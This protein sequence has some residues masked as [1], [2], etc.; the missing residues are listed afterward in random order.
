MVS[1]DTGGYRDP[2]ETA[3]ATNE[4]LAVI[5]PCVRTFGSA[6]SL[7]HL[8]SPMLPAPPAAR[9][10]HQRHR[11][12]GPLRSIWPAP[13]GVMTTPR[14]PKTAAT[15]LESLLYVSPRTPPGKDFEM[16]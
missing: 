7:H 8:K 14:N 3:S 1:T 15:I 10:G 5:K 9:T 12:K 4:A 11:K 2:L 16:K 13:P 6:L